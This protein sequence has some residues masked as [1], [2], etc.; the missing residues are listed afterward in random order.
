MTSSRP[1][2]LRGIYE[3]IVDNQLTPYILV[4]ATLEGVEVPDQYVE[5]GKIILNVSPSA[6][7]ELLIN[8]QLVE[9]DASFS[10]RALHLQVPIKAVLAIYARENGKGMVF[11]QEDV[12]EFE[13][14]L[15]KPPV[16]KK[17]KPKLT[18]VRSEPSDVK[19]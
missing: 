3:W 15:P 12:D 19:E 8:N 10:G 2:L 1:Y 14:P 11:N 17:D 4:D 5:G 7:S 9:F 16:V 18:I 13:A 6:V